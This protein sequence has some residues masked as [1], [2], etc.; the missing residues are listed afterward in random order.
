MRKKGQPLVKHG[1]GSR[2]HR[3]ARSPQ[4]R[5]WLAWQAMIWRCYCRT[6]NAF[7][8]YGGRGIT[9]C[10]QW[11]N[12]F[13]AF[14]E[15]M[16]PTPKGATL[17]RI[18]NGGNYTPSNCRWETAVQQAN[19]KRNNRLITFN[20]QTMTAANWARKTCLPYHRILQRLERGWSVKDA[21]LKPR[22]EQKNLART[23]G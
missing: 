20:G 4:Y 6:N 19:N 5:V 8:N 11:R 3:R 15:D 12:S 10:R 7:H 16:G 9:V 14:L 1:F 13:N 22:R 17:G 18:N 21:I 23:H 2:R